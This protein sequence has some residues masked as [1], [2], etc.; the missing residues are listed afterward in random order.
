MET[1]L[2]PGDIIVVPEKAP[3]VA[4]RNFTPL[5]QTAQVATSVAL[6]I[7]YLKP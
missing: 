3:K 6:A 5:M 4:A 2:M 7:A 1:V